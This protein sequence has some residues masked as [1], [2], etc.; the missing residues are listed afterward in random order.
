TMSTSPYTAAAGYLTLSSAGSTTSYTGTSQLGA[1]W[2]ALVITLKP[3]TGGG[4]GGGGGGG[5]LTFDASYSPASDWTS[6]T[7]PKTQTVTATA[8][9]LIIVLGGTADAGTTLVTPSSSTGGPGTWTQLQ[10]STVTGTCAGYAWASVMP[11]PGALTITTTTLPAAS[12][13]TAYSQTLAAT[14]G[15][16]A[17]YTWSVSS[18]SL[19]AWAS[20]S[21]GGVISGTPSG[22]GTVSFT[23]QVTDSGSNTDTQALSINTTGSVNPTWDLSGTAGPWTLQ[24]N[25]G[26]PWTS[27]PAHWQPGWFG[28]SGITPPVNSSSPQNNSAYVTISGGYLNLKVDSTYGSLVNTNPGNSATATGFTLGYP[29]AFEARINVPGPFGSTLVPNWLAWWTDGQ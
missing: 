2:A 13:G 25:D 4:G 21:A 15:T 14:G 22:S 5:P 9:D 6:T 29:C 10:S 11:A 26:S 3:G 27:L 7:T 20:L 1:A 17:G 16:G 12:V 28:A 18:G 24:L 19:P 8:G 23:V